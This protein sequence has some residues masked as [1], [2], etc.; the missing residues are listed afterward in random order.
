M[1]KVLDNGIGTFSIAISI[2]MFTAHVEAADTLEVFDPGATDLELQFCAGGFGSWAGKE[3]VGG[4]LVAGFGIADRVSI[5]S[6][7]ALQIDDDFGSLCGRY[8]LGVY[9]TPL[10]TDHVDLDVIMG[11]NGS[12]GLGDLEFAPGFEINLDRHPEMLSFGLYVDIFFLILV[13]FFEFF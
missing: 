10:E 3:A 2:L 8:S 5:Y 6:G 12:K 1:S 13:I 7:A 9:G 11:I 4:Q